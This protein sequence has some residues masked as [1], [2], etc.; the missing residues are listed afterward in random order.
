M[1]DKIRRRMKVN[2]FI[3]KSPG[4]DSNLHRGELKQGLF[5]NYSVGAFR[6]APN[7]ELKYSNTPE[8]PTCKGLEAS[9]CMI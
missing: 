7:S 8:R 2:I 1:L 4:G 3:R 9:H 6:K 5:F